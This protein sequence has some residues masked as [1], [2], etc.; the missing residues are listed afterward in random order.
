VITQV[1]IAY[2]GARTH[3]GATISSNPQRIVDKL[4][5]SRKSASPASF[6]KKHEGEPRRIRLHE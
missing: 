5:P 3:P 2:M 1:C 4:P 6:N